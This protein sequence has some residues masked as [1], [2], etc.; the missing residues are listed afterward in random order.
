MKL[1]SVNL[2]EKFEFVASFAFFWFEVPAS[3]CSNTIQYN[4]MQCN[5]MQC[6]AM[7]CNAVQYNTIQY[8]VN[9]TVPFKII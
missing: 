4:A 8:N 1:D 2:N 5:A 9:V 3:M 7:Q 6:N